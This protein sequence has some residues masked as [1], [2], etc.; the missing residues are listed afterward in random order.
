VMP[1]TP[2]PDSPPPTPPDHR[3]PLLATPRE[4]WPLDTQTLSHRSL[5]G[6]TTIPTPR[7]Y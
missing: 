3:N 5:W 2:D 1:R 4:D 7:I 6:D